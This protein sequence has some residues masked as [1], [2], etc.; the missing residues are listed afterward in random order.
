VEEKSHTSTT[1]QSAAENDIQD[2]TDP[3]SSSYCLLSAVRL[4]IAVN[5]LYVKNPKRNQKEVL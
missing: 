1:H 5:N 3:Q 4:A 2:G